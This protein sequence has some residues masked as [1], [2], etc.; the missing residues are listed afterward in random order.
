M[1]SQITFHG[2]YVNAGDGVVVFLLHMLLESVGRMETDDW[3]QRVRGK[4]ES[5]LL[6]GCG[7]G[8]YEIDLEKLVTNAQ[9][10][11]RMLQVFDG[12]RK[13]IKA[14]GP[15]V[16]KE[17]LNNLKPRVTIYFEDEETSRFL[18]KLDQIEGLLA[19]LPS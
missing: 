19:H 12:A 4:W 11:Q 8:C 1:P 18:E 14:H 17:W 10:K 2:K 7:F 13:A 5:R 3:T 16:K 15:Y 9:E 6:R